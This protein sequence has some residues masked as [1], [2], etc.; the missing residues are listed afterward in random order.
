MVLEKRDPQGNAPLPYYL[1]TTDG[2]FRLT[3]GLNR[4]IGPSMSSEDINAA[5]EFIANDGFPMPGLKVNHWRV[6]GLTPS[7][8]AVGRHAILA[9]SAT[10]ILVE[11]ET[12]IFSIFGLDTRQRSVPDKAT[13]PHAYLS[14]D[15]ARPLKV[16]LQ[17][18]IRDFQK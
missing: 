17:L 8:H 13:E 16:T 5:I 12:R 11:V 3:I 9:V 2:P 14:F 10:G 18:E 7:S 1:R 15:F 4:E 6:T